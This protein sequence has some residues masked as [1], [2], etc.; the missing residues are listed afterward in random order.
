M[1]SKEKH[2]GVY[3]GLSL[4]WDYVKFL[5]TH[6][7]STNLWDVISIFHYY[8]LLLQRQALPQVWLQPSILC[9][10]KQLLT[11]NKLTRFVESLHND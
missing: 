7:I 11:P 5:A 6:H 8:F 9:S 3:I 2:T 4:P 1:S 10:I